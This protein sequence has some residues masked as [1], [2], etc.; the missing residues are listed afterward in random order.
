MSWRGKRR[1]CC[2]GGVG[3]IRA[4]REDLVIATEDPSLRLVPMSND[5]VDAY[6][7]L[8]VRNRE[9]LTQHGDY[10][11]VLT[12]TRE[13]VC[14]EF[15]AARDYLMYGMWLEQELIGRVD[16][17]PKGPG[18]FVIGY[19]L[20]HEFVGRGLMTMACRAL[21]DHARSGLGAEMVYAGVTKGN[22]ASER[23]LERVGFA[24]VQD[25][26]SYNRFRLDLV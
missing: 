19:W 4:T 22:R 8:L 7:R 16:L 10:R 18:I 20:G 11:D 9:H 24:W 21:I 2:G 6:F 12:A 26:G 25:M 5:D 17:I 13:T 3:R 15:G 14:A 23:V 1:R